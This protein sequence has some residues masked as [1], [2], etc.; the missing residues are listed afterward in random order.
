MLISFC[1]LS[2]I[3]WLAPSSSSS[4]DQVLVSI[5]TFDVADYWHETFVL[6]FP[7]LVEP[8]WSDIALCRSVSNNTNCVSVWQR[9]PLPSLPVIH[10]L[11][12]E[13][14][15]EEEQDPYLHVNVFASPSHF[16]VTSNIT[17]RSRGKSWGGSQTFCTEQSNLASIRSVGSVRWSGKQATIDADR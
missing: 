7:L 11:E 14:E 6:F 15:V 1:R 2:S 4:S 12:E 3:Y 10:P 17:R 8:I 16:Q 5:T 9:F 13:E